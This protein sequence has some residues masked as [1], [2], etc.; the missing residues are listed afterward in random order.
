MARAWSD[1]RPFSTR[2]QITPD[3]PFLIYAVKDWAA[4]VTPSLRA[5]CSEIPSGCLK[6]KIIPNFTYEKFF[7]SFYIP[8]F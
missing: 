1:A 2:A 8:K 4:V 5:I 3:P 7:V 6:P